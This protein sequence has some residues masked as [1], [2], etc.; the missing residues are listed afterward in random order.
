[1]QD[2]TIE[3]I[4]ERIEKNLKRAKEKI[5]NLGTPHVIEKTSSSFIRIKYALKRPQMLSL[6][7]RIRIPKLVRSQFF[8]PQTPGINTKV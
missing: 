1:M 4:K 2:I 3:T 7:V 6:K 5:H 8:C